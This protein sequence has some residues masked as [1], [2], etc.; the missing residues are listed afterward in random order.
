[1]LRESSASACS[2]TRRRSM[3]VTPM[4]SASTTARLCSES[5]TSRSELERLLR[6]NQAPG[7]SVPWPSTST[8]STGPARDLANIG[9]RCREV[10]ASGKQDSRTWPP[11]AAHR[12][13][14]KCEE[15]PARSV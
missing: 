14:T 4:L 2:S 12:E 13:F 6:R 15:S 11:I 8:S 9:Q 3:A 1:M 7:L 5:T 10:R